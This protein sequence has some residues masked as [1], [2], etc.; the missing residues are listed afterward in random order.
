MAC[1][2]F[3]NVCFT[4]GDTVNLDFQYLEEDGITPIDLTGATAQMQLLNSITD[5]S[6]VDDLNGGITDAVNG[7]GRFSL[8]N[9]ESQALLPIVLD[10]P[11][12]INLVSKLRFTFADTTTLSVAGVNFSFEQSGIR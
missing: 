10:G 4:A 8:T 2:T 9:T 11:A 5:V 7:S 1:V 6:Q 3:A 12:N